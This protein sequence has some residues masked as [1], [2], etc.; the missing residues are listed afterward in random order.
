MSPETENAAAARPLAS[1]PA[2]SRGTIVRI[3]LEDP[4]TAAEL[5]ALRLLPGES[6][7][8]IEVVP[9]GGPVLVHT[10]GGTYAL[11]RRLAARIEV[12]DAA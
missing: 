3:P 9:F 4:G 11:G 6:V 8:V 12:R 10:P 1:L 5:A 2:G 7:E